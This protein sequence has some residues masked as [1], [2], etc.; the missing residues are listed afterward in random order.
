MRRLPAA[1]LLASAAAGA[2]AAP[3]SITGHN[4]DVYMDADTPY[5]LLEFAAPLANI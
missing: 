4:A 2:G 3:V 5:M 1:L